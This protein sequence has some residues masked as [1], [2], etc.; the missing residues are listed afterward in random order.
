MEKVN[1]SGFRRKLYHII[2]ESE[3]RSGKIFDIC[4]LVVILLSVLVVA[5][6]SV[7]SFRAVFA[8]TF[9][10]AEVAFTI[11][12]TI[13]YIL[14]IYSTPRPLKYIFSFFGIVDLL[15]I[16]PTY[17]TLL[18]SGAYALLIIRVLRLL[19][20]ARIFKLTRFITE[21]EVLTRALRASITKILVFLGAV[22]TVVVIVGAIMYLVE[23]PE[24]GY[25]NI[26]VSIYW[27]IVT[28]TT[29]GYGDIVPHTTLGKLLS[30][31][32]MI[33]GYG[34]IAVPTGIVSVELAR[35][36]KAP[37]ANRVCSNCFTEGHRPSAHYCYNCGASLVD[38]VNTDQV[39]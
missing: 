25:D 19:R 17:L 35:S 15:A 28:L 34:I 33:M 30:S 37:V 22:S 10:W 1:R 2:F 20:I 32:V 21:G 6:E 5:L 23:G 7:N 8:S 18:H 26:P 13:E 11:L 27:T 29:V 39:I 36:D 14:R 12:F 24:N 9:F 38:P 16:V 4:L 31:F 3:T